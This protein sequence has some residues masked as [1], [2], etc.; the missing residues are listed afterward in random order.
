[1]SFFP[2]FGNAPI[3][4]NCSESCLKEIFLKVLISKV[5]VFAKLI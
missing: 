5:D 3:R 1:M 2:K 4:T